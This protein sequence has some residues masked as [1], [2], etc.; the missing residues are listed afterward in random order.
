MALHN[1]VK[2]YA[3]NCDMPQCM[4]VACPVFIFLKDDRLTTGGLP[5]IMG[6]VVSIEEV[7]SGGVDVTIQ[8]DDATLPLVGDP[9]AK[10][11]IEFP[12]ASAEG[13]AC[14]PDCAG[15]CDWV[16]K[17]QRMLESASPVSLLT[18]HY[19]LF[20]DEQ[21]VANGSFLLPRIPFVP[22]LRLS[23]VR[24]T[25]FTYDINT[26]GTFQLKVGATVKAEYVGNLA[27]QRQFT[28][29]GADL[30][31]DVLPEFTISGLTNGV[32]GLAAAGLVVEIMGIHI[33][34]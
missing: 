34:S 26:S 5:Y 3:D 10:L 19:I 6:T 15:E 23:D 21:D 13:T 30:L 11:E 16:T 1:V 24:I 7:S 31:N 12:S 14:N 27:Q 9:A 33:P 29:L 32:Y 20:T 22:G 17:V 4:C 28:I 25:C 18:R 8:Y 2:H